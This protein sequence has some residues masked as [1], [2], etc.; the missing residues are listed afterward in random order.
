MSIPRSDLSA[1]FLF[2]FFLFDPQTRS[3]SQILIIREW[4]CQK[5]IL[6]RV[7]RY[8]EVDN[9]QILLENSMKIKWKKQKKWIWYPIHIWRYLNKW[10]VQFFLKEMISS[11]VFQLYLKRSF[12]FK[13]TKVKKKYSFNIVRPTIMFEHD[14]YE[15]LFCNFTRRK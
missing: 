10:S 4:I 13:K 9:H 2:I 3:K 1:L 12:S 15:R 5:I 11:S 7:N 8:R 14:R 6:Y